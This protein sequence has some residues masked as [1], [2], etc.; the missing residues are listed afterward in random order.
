MGV[1][2]RA[3]F[4]EDLV[5]GAFGLGADWPGDVVV[6]LP[7]ACLDKEVGP[8]GEGLAIEVLRSTVEWKLSTSLWWF[9]APGG[10]KQCSAPRWRTCWGKPWGW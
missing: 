5:G 10:M 4:Q 1:A 8:V 2:L 6:Q 7:E 9:L 3:R